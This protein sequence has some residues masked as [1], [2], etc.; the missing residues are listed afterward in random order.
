MLYYIYDQGGSMNTV[1]YTILSALLFFAAFT[2]FLLR[3][4]K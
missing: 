4:S 2:Y 3:Q 1:V